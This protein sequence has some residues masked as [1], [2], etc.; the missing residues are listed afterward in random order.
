MVGFKLTDLQDNQD[1]WG[2]IT[3]PP[4]FQDVPFMPYSKGE[5]LG[6][7]ADFGQQ[8]GQQRFQGMLCFVGSKTYYVS[9]HIF[10]K[11]HQSHIPPLPII[12]QAGS[13]NQQPVPS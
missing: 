7:I 12:T 9:Y 8:P 2:P 11:T 3:M 1:G 4:E 6:R 5:R 13:V 10:L